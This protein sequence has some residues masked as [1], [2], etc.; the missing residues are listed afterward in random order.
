MDRMI[1]IFALV[2]L[3]PL[4]ASSA[5]TAQPNA[6][7]LDAVVRVLVGGSD[8]AGPIAQRTGSGVLVG[9]DGSILTAYHTVRPPPSGWAV[10]DLGLSTLRIAVA[11]R[12]SNTGLLSDIRQATVIQADPDH[13]AALLRFHGAPRRGI[14][15]CPALALAVGDPVVV[16]AAIPR[17]GSQ[18]PTLSIR[19]G[20]LVEPVP[21]DAPYLR[22]SATAD[23]GFSGGP[24]FSVRPDGSWSLFGLLK[25]GAPLSARAESLFVPLTALRQRVVAACDEPCRHPDHGIERYTSTETSQPH[26]SDWLRGGSDRVRY[27]DA[28]AEAVRRNHIGDIITVVHTADNDHRF[29]TGWRGSQYIVREAQYKYECQ[30]RHDR[31]PIYAMRTS[32]SCPRPPNPLNLPW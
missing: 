30:L 4:S 5:S 8:S 13:D 1:F 6:E 19:Q 23:E 16:A 21:G 3:Y 28:Y 32:L 27:C 17:A 12:D 25:A 7:A 10:D 14:A 31:G 22:F 24:V 15:T 9:T 26:V 29:F 18:A 2:L 11:L 20:L